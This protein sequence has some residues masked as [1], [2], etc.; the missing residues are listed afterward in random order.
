MSTHRE[1]SN[2]R[3][4]YKNFH[5]DLFLGGGIHSFCSLYFSMFSKVFIKTNILVDSLVLGSRQES[6]QRL[7]GFGERNVDTLGKT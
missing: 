6:W 1:K 4:L 3:Q 7:T 2:Y 5:R